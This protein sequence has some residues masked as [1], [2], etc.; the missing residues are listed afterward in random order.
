VMSYAD[1]FTN[2]LQEHFV[3]VQWDQRETGRTLETNVSPVPLTVSVFENDTYELVKTLLEKFH[4]PKLY[5]VGHSWG[6][7]LGF[8]M[9]KQHPDLLYAYVA[10]GSMID[11]L[12]SE[13]ISLDILRKDAEKENNAVALKELS[14]IKVP[15]ENGEQ[16]Y[17]HRKWLLRHSGSKTKLSKGYVTTWAK[18]WLPVYNEACMNNKFETTPTLNC[19]VYFFAGRKDLQTN[20]SITEKYFDKLQV[21]KKD[22][23]WFE[24]SAHGIPTS[25]P[26]KFQQ[27]IIEKI[28]P[29]TFSR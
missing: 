27:V 3:V 23:V 12:D 1:K 21:P 7:V 5:L 2:K 29:E 15:F 8:F 9:A 20:S 4:Q 6:T 10:V 25:E 17:Y 13:R 18:T 16:L 14:T 22:L 26:I 24:R 19:P 28:L 11:Q